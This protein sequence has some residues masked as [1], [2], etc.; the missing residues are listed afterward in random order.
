MNV[1]SMVNQSLI[2]RRLTMFAPL[3][4]LLFFVCTCWPEPVLSELGQGT[5][6]NR[7]LYFSEL[8]EIC[9]IKILYTYPRRAVYSNMW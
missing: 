8:Y 1:D 5:S 3:V 2:Y 6:E 9:G 4:L 7:T